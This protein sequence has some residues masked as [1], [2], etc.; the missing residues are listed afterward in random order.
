MT[1][2]TLS[3]ADLELA[4]RLYDAQQRYTQAKAELDE[5]KTFARQQLPVGKYKHNDVELFTIGEARL[6]FKEEKARQIVPEELHDDCRSD[7]MNGPITHVLLT[8]KFGDV[9]GETMYR[10]CCETSERPVTP[11]KN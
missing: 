4:L 5:Q 3:N 7:A 11:G 6:N 2:P 10:Q 8:A 1:T 9:L